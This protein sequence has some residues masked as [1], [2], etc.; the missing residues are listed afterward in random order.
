M[1]TVAVFIA[2]GGGA[3]A[4]AT[5]NSGDV[6]NE[7]LKSVDVKNNQL[8]SEDVLDDSLGAVDLG[9]DS[10]HSGELAFNSVGTGQAVND[11]LTGEDI[12]ESSLGKVPSAEAAGQAFRSALSVAAIGDTESQDAVTLRGLTLELRCTQIEGPTVLEV[13]ARSSDPDA[14]LNWGYVHGPFSNSEDDGTS[15]HGGVNLTKTTNWLLSEPAG[16]PRRLVGQFIYVD[17]T[18]IVAVDLYAVVR[19]GSCT[20]YGVALPG[21]S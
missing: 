5:V 9:N 20:T 7:S 4:A 16:I 13:G 2:I 8:K 10:V 15:R 14:T 3:Y 6:V 18:D 17:D 21:G 1:A 19:H 12:A 11:G